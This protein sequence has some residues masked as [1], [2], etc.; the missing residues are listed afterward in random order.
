MIVHFI[1]LQ[2]LQIRLHSIGISNE[3][4]KTILHSL[5]PA[6]TSDPDT[7][8]VWSCF[9]VTLFIVTTL[10]YIFDNNLLTGVYPD[11][12][13]RANVTSVHIK[14]NKQIIRN[15]R[16]I[17]LLPTLFVLIVARIKFRDFFLIC[18]FR[19]I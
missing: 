5:N 15:Y 17:S 4:I 8:L 9:K 18:D 3:D 19:D 10:K 14:E 13:K 1:S 12:W 11:A 16:H 7:M 6:K 2:Y